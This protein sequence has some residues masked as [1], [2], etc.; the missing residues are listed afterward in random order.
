MYG[1]TN[2]ASIQAT[3]ASCSRN[4]WNASADWS[5][6]STAWKRNLSEKR[7]EITD[8]D[9]VWRDGVIERTGRIMKLG[10]I[11]LIVVGLLVIVG[12][13]LGGSLVG[14]HNE[15]VTEREA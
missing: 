12:L 4:I 9:S 8:A 10:L 15:L 14:S 11:A 13:V 1:K 6:S 7:K 2:R 5:N 3:R